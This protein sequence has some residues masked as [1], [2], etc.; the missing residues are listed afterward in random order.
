MFKSSECEN[1]SMANSVSVNGQVRML[2]VNRHAKPASGSEYAPGSGSS[3]RQDEGDA[4]RGEKGL[5]LT[6]GARERSTKHGMWSCGKSEV[7]VERQ[8][9]T[10]LNTTFTGARMSPLAARI[11]PRRAS[12]ALPAVALYPLPKMDGPCVCAVSMT[13]EK[14]AVH[15]ERVLVVEECILV[16]GCL[17]I[18]LNSLSYI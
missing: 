6:R 11:S 8:L 3:R 16:S 12:P 4:V 10:L 9:R 15:L 18:E 5:A 7:E 14:F 2:L 1:Q 13:A 17:V